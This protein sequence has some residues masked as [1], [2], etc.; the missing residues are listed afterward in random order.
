MTSSMAARVVCASLGFFLLAGAAR[1][2]YAECVTPDNVPESVYDT[3]IAEAS[4]Q[5][6]TLSQKACDAIVKAGTATCKVQTK[7]SGHCFEHAVSTDYAIT[8]K[9]CA[10][11]PMAVDRQT[12]V[13]DAKTMRD[14]LRAEL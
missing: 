11:L 9:Q 12:C 2:Q 10:Q 13:T 6:G 4:A 3:I 7:G 1:A 5:F 14:G 8:L